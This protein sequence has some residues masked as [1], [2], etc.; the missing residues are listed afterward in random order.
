MNNNGKKYHLEMLEKPQ[1]ECLVGE[2]LEVLRELFLEESLQ[3][4]LR[5]S[6]EQFLE[7][8]LEESNRNFYLKTIRHLR[9]NFK[10]ISAAL[11]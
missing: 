7:K 5:E 8:S 2:F 4:S 6:S 3:K 9:R 11:L 1:Q 10:R